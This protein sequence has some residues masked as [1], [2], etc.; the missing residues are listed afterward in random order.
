MDQDEAGVCSKAD[1][2]LKRTGVRRLIMGH[3]PTLTHIVSRCKGKVIII[4]TGTPLCPFC[5]W[6]LIILGL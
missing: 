6:V 1:D 2:V 5:Y 3:T 4:D